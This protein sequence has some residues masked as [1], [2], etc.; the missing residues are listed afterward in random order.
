MTSSSLSS[1]NK[2]PLLKRARSMQARLNRLDKFNQVLFV[3]TASS[4]FTAFISNMNLS[5]L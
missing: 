3:V 1:L 4:I 2:A 5:V